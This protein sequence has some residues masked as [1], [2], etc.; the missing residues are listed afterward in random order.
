M[1][2]LHP[3]AG[4]T[5]PLQGL[6]LRLHDLAS[7]DQ[8]RPAIYANF[9]SSLDGRIA[10]KDEGEQHYKLPGSLK[11]DEDFQLFLEL[12]AHADCIVTHG[13][14]M[15]SLAEGRLGNVLQIPNHK[16]TRYIHE[17]RADKGLPKHPDLVIVSGSLEFPWHESLDSSQQTVH[18]ATGGMSEQKNKQSWQDAGH[19]VHE[20][21][22]Q[23]DVDVHQLVNFL[24]RQGYQSVYLV[25]GPQLLQD[26]MRQHYVDRF[27]VTINHQLLGGGDF[28]TMLS[29][30]IADDSR[31]MR[32]QN[33]HMSVESSNGVGQWFADFTIK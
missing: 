19:H 2:C 30:K 31:A 10:V 4:K 15:R 3:D 25:A 33:L 14:Y 7:S 12:F 29:E 1:I 17:W 27:F 8:S 20:F 6:Y 16:W 24:S 5:V 23:H 22:G 21:G 11:S 13:G 9:L 26:L 32:L 28:K 18:I